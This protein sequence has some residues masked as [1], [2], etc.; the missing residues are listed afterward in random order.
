MGEL[1]N[2][3]LLQ[4]IIQ[5][6]AN[7]CI[8]TRQYVLGAM[9]ARL[10]YHADNVQSQ[11]QVLSILSQQ[12]SSLKT[13]RNVVAKEIVRASFGELLV[14]DF[15]QRNKAEQTM[16]VYIGT[17]WVELPSQMYKDFIRDACRKAGLDEQ[18]C[19]EPALVLGIAEQ[20]AFMVSKSTE[21]AKAGGKHLINMLNG[22]LEISTDGSV[23]L[24]EHRL[25]DYLTYVLPYAY[26]R[27]ATCDKWQAFLD[28][29]LPEPESQKVLAEFIA[30][31]LTRGIKLEKMLVL[32]GTGANGK[33]VVLD[34][35]TSLLGKDNV[36]CAM[37]SSLTTDETVRAMLENKLVNISTE[38]GTNVEPS[39]AKALI[40]N[41]PIE[42]RHL[43]HDPRYMYDY[44][45][46][47]GAYN[48]L[49]KAE[50][51]QG[52]FRRFQI[53]PFLVTISDKDA[54]L[55][56]TDKLKE[57]LPGIFNWVLEGLRR[58][59]ANSHK[60][61]ESAVCNEALKKYVLSSDPVRLFLSE[62]CE[63]APDATITAKALHD[64]YKQFCLDEDLR[65]T[66]SRNKFYERVDQLVASYQLNN[67]K[68]FRTRLKYEYE[69]PL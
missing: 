23:T 42:I 6:T 2:D 51:T 28:Q 69:L 45:K 30:Y 33:S 67:Q 63:T 39:A 37:L 62:R 1:T 34:I 29:M 58:F 35:I 59:I 52:Y 26:D 17:H 19:S 48:V 12:K 55:H 4:D 22:T 13:M 41:E 56:L 38:N 8:D 54:D 11:S 57:E 47:I 20:V 9:K 16:S 25:D 7:A 61:T 68:C 50:N 66:L 53:L 5:K 31:C 27:H 18:Q 40:S 24:R 15:S 60:L 65:Y 21:T 43:Y 32:F 36:S 44:A 14:K 10:D 46:L 49:P 3:A 64:A